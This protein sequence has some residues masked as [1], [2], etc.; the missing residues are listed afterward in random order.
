[1]V[2]LPQAA[3]RLRVCSSNFP[4][5]FLTLFL[6]L[7]LAPVV[8]R[9][10]TINV[11]AGGNLQGA[12]NAAQPGDTIVLQAN[13]TYVGPLTLPEKSGNSYITIQSSALDQLP[14]EG[15]R[16]TPA[17]ASL[18]P[19]I[20]SPGFGQSALDTAHRAHHY[21]LVGI[22]FKPANSSVF[23]YD[24]VSLGDGGQ[25]QRSLD[26]VAHH[27]T[28]DRCYIHPD[29]T[30]HI[31]RG[32]ALNSA[33]T[34]II[35]SYIS[36]FKEIQGETQAI[37]GWNGPGPYKIINNYL[38]GAAETILFGG[39]D[40][41]VW[42]LVPSDIEIRRNHF[43]KPPSWGGTWLVKHLIE[44]KNAQNVRVDGNIM[45]QNWDGVA[46]L[47]TPRNQDGRAPWTVVQNVEFT[48]NIIRYV[49]SII[50]ILGVDYNAPSRQTNRI[51]LRNNLFTDVD[52]RWGRNG[53][54]MVITEAADVT[55]DHNT[56]F[57]TDSIT[58]A[59]GRPTTGFV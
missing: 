31:K 44:L 46:L 51:T 28:I 47:L 25:G 52:S 56:S 5:H 55:M 19:K 17:H 36:N 2:T 24:M 10:A 49:G 21:R 30:P 59:Y 12:V 4:L 29:A 48:N 1:M 26:V 58:V 23:V 27:I 33:D 18:M 38:E 9:A 53:R 15:Q 11:P 20:V 6:V 43:Y 8:A 35:N 13:A 32:I 39:S 16:V 54:L 34:E 50:N 45:E 3:L 22:E 40:P 37:C 57:Q 42:G 41:W 14:G 7:L